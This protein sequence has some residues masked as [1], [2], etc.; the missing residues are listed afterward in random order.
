MKKIFLLAAT[1]L[2][3]VACNWDSDSNNSQ[4]APKLVQKVTLA[5]GS[6]ATMSYDTGKTYPSEIVFSDGTTYSLDYSSDYPAYN[7]FITIS[8][9]GIDMT[10]TLD[11][12]YLTTLTAGEQ[13]IS[14]F[15]Y[16]S[17]YGNNLSKLTRSLTPAVSKF[18]WFNGFYVYLISRQTNTFYEEGSDPATATGFETQKVVSYGWDYSASNLYSYTNLLP[19]IVPEYLEC[20]GLNN[21]VL[22]AIGGLRTP[23]LPSSLKIE[24]TTPNPDEGGDENGEDGENGD[25]DEENNDNN[26]TKYTTTETL[27]SYSY[28]TDA[29]GYIRAVYLISGDNIEKLLGIDYVLNK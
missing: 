23:Y 8:S 15:T 3:A 12:G 11:N 19:I 9:D 2:T 17:A 13:T 7:S 20:A 22:A 25:G 28:D 4:P 6:S 18:E 16:N 10:L 29:E 21:V 5:D 26:D 14:E 24:T 1:A 27:R